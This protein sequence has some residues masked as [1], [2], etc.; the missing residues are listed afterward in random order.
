MVVSGN[1]AGVDLPLLIK[2]GSMRMRDVSKG[3][4][5]STWTWRKNLAGFIREVQQMPMISVFEAD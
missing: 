2:Q 5:K 3:T 1:G 4:T